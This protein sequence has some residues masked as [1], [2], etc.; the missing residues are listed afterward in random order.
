MPS[1]PESS[2]IGPGAMID[3]KFRVERVLGM[4][5]MGLVVEATHL[6]L[7][8]RVAL[9]FLRPN[10]SDAEAIE[11]I[12]R[13][14]RAA[15]RLRSV[16]V[17]RVLDVARA[18]APSPGAGLPYIVMEHL[19]GRVLAAIVR[20]NGPLPIADAA[21]FV[22]QACEAIA[23]AHAHGIVHRDLKPENLFLTTRVD[24]RPLIKVLDFGISK[25]T[26]LDGAAGEALALTR[27]ADLI[28]S[29]SYMSPEQLRHARNVDAR[30]DQWS[31]GVILFE[32]LT[33]K[34]PFPAST[35]ME[36]CSRVLESEPPPIAS[37]RADVPPALAA[38]IARCL[39]K[40]PAS[41]FASVADLAA[42]LEPFA[43]GA[44]RGAAEHIRQI[45]AGAAPR[46]RVE[47]SGGD[48]F[49][50]TDVAW[51]ETQFGISVRRRPRRW[52]AAL[53]VAAIALVALASLVRHRLMDAPMRAA[54]SEAEPAA[55]S[56]P[57]APRA[58]G[59]APHRPIVPGLT[60]APDAADA[61]SP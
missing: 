45:M 33:G 20:G 51:A 31:L 2:G 44:E 23:E 4:G 21:G 11:R 41:R 39:Q 38:A 47:P 9:K 59:L 27:T 14:A 13:E 1:R 26:P 10:R 48:R 61:S 53:V 42:V 50:A 16:H 40:D 25:L 32:L 29:P 12:L 22:L 17:A 24:G 30:T 52:I 35:I 18:V 15:A 19:A 43:A 57:V 46:G 3:G 55:P 56:A 49:G 34:L 58:P 36:L 37:L 6:A 54:S 28:G 5:G 7:Q 60:S 8:R